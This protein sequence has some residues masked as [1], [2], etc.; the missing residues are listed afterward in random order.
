MH[1]PNFGWHSLETPQKKGPLPQFPLA[2]QQGPKELP[3]QVL[4]FTFFPQ[5]P[6]VE[7]GMA[8]DVGAVEEEEVVEVGIEVVEIRDEVVIAL[9][10]YV[11][12]G[13]V[14]V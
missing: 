2:E 4:S 11:V 10:G 7:I 14:V 9:C 1:L 8:V 5:R 13:I 3:L 12:A 6:S